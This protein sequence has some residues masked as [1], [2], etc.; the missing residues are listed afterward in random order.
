MDTIR[1]GGAGPL[2]DLPL[3][4]DFR[5]DYLIRLLTFLSGVS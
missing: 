3:P 2:S 4:S 1:S 5:Y